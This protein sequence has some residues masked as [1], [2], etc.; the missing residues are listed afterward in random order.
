MYTSQKIVTAGKFTRLLEVLD[1]G[2]AHA[3]WSTGAVWKPAVREG[4]ET[5]DY[6]KDSGVFTVS[7][8]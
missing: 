1:I 4:F 7:V 6:Q 5:L 2:Q 8:G 3:P